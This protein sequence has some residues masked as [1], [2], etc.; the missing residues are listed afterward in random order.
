MLAQA[1]RLRFPIGLLKV[2]I[3]PRASMVHAECQRSAWP[4]EDFFDRA[5]FYGWLMCGFGV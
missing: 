1:L 5:R 2:G 4:L 3:A